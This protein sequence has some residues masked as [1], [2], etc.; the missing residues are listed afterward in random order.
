MSDRELFRAVVPHFAIGAILGAIFMALLLVIQVNRFSDVV[1]NS[2]N[3][4]VVTSILMIGAALYFAFGAA[5]TGFHFVI[6]AD[7]RRG[8]RR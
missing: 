7:P 1:L 5:I 4:I 6:T 2:S 3:P 8:D